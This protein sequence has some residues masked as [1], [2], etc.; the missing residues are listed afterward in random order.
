[1]G[2]SV[3][4]CVVGGGGDDWCENTQPTVGGTVP[5]M[6]DPELSKSGKINLDTSKKAYEHICIPVILLLRLGII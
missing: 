6:R 5:Q 4:V 1:M 2:M 3:C